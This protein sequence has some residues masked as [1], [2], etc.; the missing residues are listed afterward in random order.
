[1][2][3]DQW[4][5]VDLL[6]IRSERAAQGQPQGCAIQSNIHQIIVHRDRDIHG[7]GVR[8]EARQV[9]ECGVGII[10]TER[11]VPYVIQPC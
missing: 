7:R 3:S 8:I 4:E 6:K 2:G 1:M 5:G 9:K 10:R 11:L